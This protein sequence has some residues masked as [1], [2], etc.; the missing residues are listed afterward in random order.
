MKGR[1]LSPAICTTHV[2]RH[3]YNAQC[4]NA[5]CHGH[6]H[7]EVIVER[8]VS[9]DEVRE[10]TA[11]TEV[12]EVREVTEVR[13]RG[14]TQR[15]S[16]VCRIPKVRHAR[17]TIFDYSR[18]TKHNQTRY[19]VATVTRIDKFIGLFCRISSLL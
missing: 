10:V 5:Q 7:N 1:T 17:H 16:M 14:K 9:Y 15:L 13:A 2:S 12:R 8:S 3:L 4:H 18:Y 19:G 11:V 6:A